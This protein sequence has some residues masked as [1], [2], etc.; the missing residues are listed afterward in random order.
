MWNIDWF[1]FVMFLW[2]WLFPKKQILKWSRMQNVKMKSIKIPHTPLAISNS[3]I[4]HHIF[5]SEAE[6]TVNGARMD[7]S[8]GVKWWPLGLM[9]SHKGKHKS[10]FC[11]RIIQRCKNKEPKTKSLKIQVVTAK[12]FHLASYSYPDIY[13]I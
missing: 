4:I 12:I 9:Y 1:W 7:E 13:L 2:Y 5:P 6:W 8:K 11:D 3:P 10:S